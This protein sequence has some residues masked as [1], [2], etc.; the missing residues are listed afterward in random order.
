[1]K[2]VGYQLHQI[3]VHC[4]RPFRIASGL[5]DRC[6]T[7]MVTLYTD[8]ALIGYGEA[9]PIPLLTDENFEGCRATLEE[10]LLPMV[11]HREV[12]NLRELH[13]E[14]LSL[15]RGKSSRCAIDLALHELARQSA[16]LSLS[17]LLGTRQTQFR[18]NY[19]IGIEDLETTLD[20]AREILAQGYDCLKL[21]VGLEPEADIEMVVGV[22]QLLPPGARLRLDANGGWNRQSAVRVL[23][24]LEQK[25]C[26]IELVE[27]PTPREDFRALKYV[28]ERSSF[29]IAADESVHTLHDARLLL[30]HDCVDIL[31]LKLMK[32]GGLLP[33]L[34][35]VSLARAF[36]CQLMVG[37]MVGES[38]LGVGAAAAL[39]AAADFEYADLDADI[40]LRD[41]PFQDHLPGQA[42][43][44]N[45][46]PFRHWSAQSVPP[47]D[48]G[49]HLLCEWGT[50]NE[51]VRITT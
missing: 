48:P 2:I 10:Q 15:T 32:T 23:R 16:G 1:M 51:K 25:S 6:H 45:K 38:A 19:S 3:T 12:W 29:P 39:A 14:M 17:Q 4:K 21:K 28:R 46:P 44:L 30:E 42:P 13:R 35:I 41:S 27:Q 11:R 18:T 5:Q 33:A 34:D 31:N 40:L 7:L 8:N 50:C 22:S 24:A 43:L 37:G 36:G 9:V 49:H 47:L 26:P 20:L